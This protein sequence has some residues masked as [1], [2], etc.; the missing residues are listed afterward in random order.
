MFK[1]EHQIKNLSLSAPSCDCAQIL[2]VPGRPQCASDVERPPREKL[3]EYVLLVRRRR[4]VMLGCEALC[5]SRSQYW[6]VFLEG[7]L[8]S[9]PGKKEPCRILGS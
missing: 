2:S 6:W 4:C 5:V 9:H 3:K 8:K 7:V 1:M